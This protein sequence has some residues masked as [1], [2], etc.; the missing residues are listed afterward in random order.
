MR[1]ASRGGRLHHG[2]LIAGPTGVGKATL[3]W[4]YARW[5][6]AGTPEGAGTPLFVPPE[7]PVFRRVAAGA[8]ADVRGL[9]PEAGDKGKKVI[10]RVEDVREVPRFLSMT[11]AEG[12][13][14]VVVVEDAD[15]M[16]EPAQNALLK[17]LEEPPA[18]AVLLLTT[19][20]PDRLLPTIRSRVRRLDL[21]PLDDAAMDPLLARWLPEMAAVDRSSLA[22]ISGGAPGRALALADGDGLE[23]AR[24]VGAFLASLPR[25]EPRDLH[26]LADRIAGRRDGAALLTFFELLRDALARALRSAGRGQ[27]GLP[28]SPAG[29]FPTGLASGRAWGASRTRRRRSTSTG[30]ARCSRGCPA[31]SRPDRPK[32]RAGG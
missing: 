13:W 18:R 14:R 1:D 26:A 28:G 10:I 6:M 22:T 9:S 21:F 17:T 8:H 30:R 20:A 16:N 3:A 27:G 5:V 29:A 23:L 24:D 7:A 4:R 32:R 19:A 31:S 25:P 15:G 12:G 11:P 2:W